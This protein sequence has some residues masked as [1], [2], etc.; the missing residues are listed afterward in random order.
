MSDL[1]MSDLKLQKESMS[2]IQCK[3]KLDLFMN[4]AGHYTSDMIKSDIAPHRTSKIVHRTCVH[5]TPG[6]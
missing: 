1:I 6:T 5:L 2:G 3:R 4:C